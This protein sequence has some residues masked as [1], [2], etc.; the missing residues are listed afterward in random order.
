MVIKIYFVS[1][2]SY[3]VVSKLL[4]FFAKN[5]GEPFVSFRAPCAHAR[6]RSIKHDKHERIYRRLRCES[7]KHNQVLLY[8]RTP[9]PHD[10][11]C[12]AR[13]TNRMT[14]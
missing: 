12:I 6:T 5:A 11:S 1:Q 8:T 7:V 14:K 9:G 3:L 10:R 4:N 13:E 2:P